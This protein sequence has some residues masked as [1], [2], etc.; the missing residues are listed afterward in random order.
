MTETGGSEMHADDGRVEA[1]MEMHTGP[2]GED[3]FGHVREAV[4]DAVGRAGDLVRDRLGVGAALKASPLAAVGLA[5][6]AG[7]FVALTTGEANRTGFLE[8]RRRQVR[9]V[10]LSGLTAVL[11][12]ELRSVVDEEDIAEFVR[13]LRDRAGNAV[14]DLE[15]AVGR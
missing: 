9:A 3:R 11:V 4:D 12:G 5:F 15:D 8:R 14:D 6:S 1:S 13:S 2:G 10:L 7:F